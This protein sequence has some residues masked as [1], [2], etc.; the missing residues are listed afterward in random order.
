MSPE[1]LW[2]KL[3][4]QFTI[5]F[6]VNENLVICAHQQENIRIAQ[7]YIG[8]Q[9]REVRQAPSS[10]RGV[11]GSDRFQCPGI[12]QATQLLADLLDPPI[13]EA[14]TENLIIVHGIRTR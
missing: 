13:V 14:P 9:L 7:T 4:R 11:T 6:K 2:L 8:D 3:L 5:S 12:L 1:E 10:R